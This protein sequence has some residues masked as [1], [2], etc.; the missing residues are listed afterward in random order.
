MT[1]SMDQPER[2]SGKIAV[3]NLTCRRL[4]IHCPVYNSIAKIIREPKKEL[5]Y[6]SEMWYTIFLWYL[7]SSFLLHSGAAIVAF[8]ALRRHKMGRLYSLVILVMGFVGP[9]T[10][11]IVTSKGELLCRPPPRPTRAPHQSCRLSVLILDLISRLT[12][13]L[14]S[15]HGHRPT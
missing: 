5:L 3:L 6:F 12:L 4:N 9:I 14:V 15:V 11:G 10:G 8:W 2:F 7:F 13:R 1:V